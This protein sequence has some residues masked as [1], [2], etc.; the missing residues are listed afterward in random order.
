LWC[1]LCLLENK[2]P[3]RLA[4][5]VLDLQKRVISLG[6][7]YFGSA[8]TTSKYNLAFAKIACLVMAP[9][10]A[11]DWISQAYSELTVS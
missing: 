6:P 2:P 9:T 3:S 11:I 10:V 1:N 5:S 8:D 7:S 4:K